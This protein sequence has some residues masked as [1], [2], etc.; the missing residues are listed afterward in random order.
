VA[1]VV[2]AKAL[3]APS[4]RKAPWVH[5]GL[6]ARKVRLVHKGYSGQLVLLGQPVQRV[7]RDRW[8]HQD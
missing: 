8:G 4:A 7:L 5:K 3:K 2:G 6:L 1:R